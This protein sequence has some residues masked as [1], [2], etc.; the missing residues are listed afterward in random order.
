M[1]QNRVKLIAR[2][3]GSKCGFKKAAVSLVRVKK[4]KGIKTALHLM[5][6]NAT[7]LRCLMTIQNGL[8]IED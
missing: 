2:G 8:E 3:F 6:L 4:M 7:V 5:K 1:L